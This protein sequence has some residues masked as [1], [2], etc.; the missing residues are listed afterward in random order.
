MQKAR[1]KERNDVR[2]AVNACIRVFG[3]PSAPMPAP[4]G[5]ANP[6]HDEGEFRADEGPLGLL[7][8]DLRKLIYK[9]LELSILTQDAQE[10]NQP[11]SRVALKV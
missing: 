7:Q 5:S 9:L 11:Q 10:D 1:G 4:L 3:G 2:V 8:T 6:A